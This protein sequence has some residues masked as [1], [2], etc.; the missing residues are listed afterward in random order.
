[1]AI[2][3]LTPTESL[4][5]SDRRNLFCISGVATAALARTR[6]EALCGDSAGAFSGWTATELTDSAAQDFGVECSGPF[7][8]KE[9]NV[10]PRLTNGGS[11]LAI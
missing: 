1:M 5:R 4:K 7:G 3:I 8:L 2:F 10:W 9:G 6:A 11:T